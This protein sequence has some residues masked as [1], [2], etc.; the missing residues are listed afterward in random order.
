[1]IEYKEN[2]LEKGI[3]EK[4]ESTLYNLASFPKDEVKPRFVLDIEISMMKQMLIEKEES[5][6]IMKELEKENGNK[7]S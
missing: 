7:P 6:K 4:N 2:Q 3:I 1:E 5:L